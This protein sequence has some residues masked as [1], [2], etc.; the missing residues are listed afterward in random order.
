M[1]HV[2]RKVIADKMRL[3]GRHLKKLTHLK[4]SVLNSLDELISAKF[5]EP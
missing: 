2:W 3:G 5:E 1:P 4:L